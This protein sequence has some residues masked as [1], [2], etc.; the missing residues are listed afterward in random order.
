MTVAIFMAFIELR[1]S[2]MVPVTDSAIALKEEFLLNFVHG[3]NNKPFPQIGP[4]P[5][6]MLVQS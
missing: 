2:P 6:W 3:T 4:S 5:I 1:A